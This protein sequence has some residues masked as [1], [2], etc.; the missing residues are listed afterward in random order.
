MPLAFEPAWWSIAFPV[1]MYGV[2]SHELGAVLKLPWLVT[3]GR[4]EAWIALAVWVT[5]ALAMCGTFLRP[6]S[7]DYPR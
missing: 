5:V 4:V 1:G 3:L 7:T 6:G 2:A